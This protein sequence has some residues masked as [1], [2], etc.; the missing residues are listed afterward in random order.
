MYL[1][2][3]SQSKIEI[4]TFEAKIKKLEGGIKIVLVD[5]VFR[6]CD[7]PLIAQCSVKI[8]ITQ[9]KSSTVRIIK[10]YVQKIM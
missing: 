3:N 5:I 7:N 2:Q 10:F 4:T 6:L 1:P 9:K 8:G